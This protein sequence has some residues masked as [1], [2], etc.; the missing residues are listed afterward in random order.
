M[1]D[2]THPITN[3]FSGLE[4]FPIIAPFQTPTSSQQGSQIPFD[5]QTV[6]IQIESSQ[7]TNCDIE[8]TSSLIAC[9]LGELNIGPAC[10]KL[11]QFP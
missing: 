3:Y 1:L 5:L 6:S 10:P 4:L 2:N 7:V 8:N 9:D 11:I